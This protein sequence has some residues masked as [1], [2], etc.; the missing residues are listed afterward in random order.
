MEHIKPK[1]AEDQPEP[2]SGENPDRSLRALLLLEVLANADAPLSLAQLCDRLAAPKAT[3]LR[4]LVALERLG[5]LLREVDDKTYLLGPRAS[6][7]GL[8]LLRNQVVLQRSR[9]VLQALVRQLGETC[10]LTALD[11]DSVIYVDRV[12]TH[13]PLRLHVEPGTHV[14]LH[15]TASG[16][17]FLAEMPAHRRRDI[18]KQLELTPSSDRSITDCDLLES[19]LERIRARGVG[20]DSEEFVRGMV[21]VAVPIRGADGQCLAALACH[22]PTARKSLNELIE[23]IP[24]LQAAAAQLALSLALDSSRG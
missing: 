1:F 6:R 15:C 2:V 12:E 13:E 20:I 3:L 8:A 22:A 18:L 9:L 11:G 17:L 21:A 16:K 14:P 7:L 19:E 10:N 4:M 5:F 24:Q 23:Y